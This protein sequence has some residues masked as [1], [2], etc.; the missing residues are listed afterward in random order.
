MEPASLEALSS[1]GRRFNGR[2]YI[3]LG[4]ILIILLA[5]GIFAWK[6]G[7]FSTLLT[8][9]ETASLPDTDVGTRFTLPDGS[10]FVLPGRHNASEFPYPATVTVE[11]LKK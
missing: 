7:T 10:S 4:F 3:I 5:G 9:S 11:P 8:T 6:S 2:L 1:K